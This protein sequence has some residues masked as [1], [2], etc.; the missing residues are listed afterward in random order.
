MPLDSYLVELFRNY[1][2]Y[3]RGLSGFLQD[4]K[5]GVC[6]GNEAIRPRVDDGIHEF[7]LYMNI[8][9]YT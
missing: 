9:I 4:V 2:T 5:I 3:R 7:Y 6:E 8:K 1:S